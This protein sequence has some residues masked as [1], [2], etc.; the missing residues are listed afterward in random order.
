MG[1]TSI[2]STL[3]FPLLQDFLVF[4]RM[5][6]TMKIGDSADTQSRKV[7][8]VSA[9]Y[10]VCNKRISVFSIPKESPS[11]KTASKATE[12]PQASHTGHGPKVQPTLTQ[13]EIIAL[14]IRARELVTERHIEMM[15]DPIMGYGML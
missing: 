14:Q 5:H 1:L 7:H 10:A 8:P 6:S 2:V 15:M 4:F 13:S 3:R 12:T 11:T 9:D